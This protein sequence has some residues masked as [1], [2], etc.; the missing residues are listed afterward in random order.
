MIDTDPQYRLREQ[1]REATYINQ[2]EKMSSQL[3]FDDITRV[4]ADYVPVGSAKGIKAPKKSKKKRVT[5]PQSTPSTQPLGG[6]QQ[7]ITFEATID[8]VDEEGSVKKGKKGRPPKGTP[9]LT[10]ERREAAKV[11]QVMG[12]KLTQVELQLLG[13]DYTE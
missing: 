4:L 6:Q 5:K 8:T 3:N 10:S 13:K 1:E 2:A 9:K 11:R 7:S 12:I